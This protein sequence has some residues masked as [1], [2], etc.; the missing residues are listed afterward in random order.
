MA[1]IL[2]RHLNLYTVCMW[3][4]P[5]AHG[6]SNPVE[7][8]SGFPLT[9]PIIA[10]GSGLI[11]QTWHFILATWYWLFTPQSQ[12]SINIWSIAKNCHEILLSTNWL[13]IVLSSYSNCKVKINLY[14]EAADR[15]FSTMLFRNII[16]KFFQPNKNIVATLRKNVITT[17]SQCC[18]NSVANVIFV[19]WVHIIML[20]AF[21]G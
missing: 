20:A 21:G 2:I 10:L 1:F 16:T 14:P 19:S 15:H 7:T 13:C 18:N 11:K 3:G 6:F 17:L 4:W 9:W 8:E 12:F 5:R